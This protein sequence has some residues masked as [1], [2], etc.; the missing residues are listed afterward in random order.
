MKGGQMPPKISFVMPC[1]NGAF[2]LNQTIDSLFAQDEDDF[3]VI[4]VNDSS[5]DATNNILR[6]ITD[7]RFTIVN[8]RNRG[9]AGNARNIG[10]DM[11]SAPIIAVVDCGDVLYPNRASES[12]R[13]FESFKDVDIMCAATD[14]LAGD[15]YIEPRLFMSKS[16]EKLGFEHPGV[17]YC[18]E[19]TDVIKYRT[20]S[21]ETDQYDAFFFEAGRHG[22][23]F[24]VYSQPLLAKCTFEQYSGGRN[25]N[26]A[27]M[28]KAGIYREFKVPLPSWLKEHERRFAC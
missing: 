5:S 17:T 2:V 11:A 10:N 15:R 13:Y 25:L 6:D 26:K 21:L 22:F 12:I 28:V 4:I 27:L 20:T 16:G 19:V 3:E 24:G 9:G 23:K 14:S 8:L 1:W 7:Q 18:K